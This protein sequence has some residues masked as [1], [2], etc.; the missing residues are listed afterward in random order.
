MY[1]CWINDMKHCKIDWSFLNYNNK[2]H[3]VSTHLLIFPKMSAIKF[4]THLQSWVENVA[5]LSYTKYLNDLSHVPT[6]SILP[7]LSSPLRDVACW[8]RSLNI[9]SVILRID[10]FQMIKYSLLICNVKKNVCSAENA[11]DYNSF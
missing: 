4:E 1:L 3:L 8:R 2:S 10:F 5:I 7:I 6:H 11:I 9:P